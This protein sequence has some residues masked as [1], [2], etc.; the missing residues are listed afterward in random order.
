E[1]HVEQE[2]AVAAHRVDL[3]AAGAD[4]LQ[5]LEQRLRDGIGLVVSDPG[6]EQVAEQ[7]QVAGAA[8]LRIEPLEEQRGGARIV[9]AQVHVGAEQRDV[10]RCS[11]DFDHFAPPTTAIE[12]ITTASAGTS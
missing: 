2:I 8:R 9:V 4:P 7:E 1:G 3:R 11:S 5:S 6:L 10:A 12:S